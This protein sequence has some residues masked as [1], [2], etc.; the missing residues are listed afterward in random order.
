MYKATKFCILGFFKPGVKLGF[1]FI[2]ILPNK[3]SRTSYINLYFDEESNPIVGSLKNSSSVKIPNFL[4][5]K[6]KMPEI[7]FCFDRKM[8]LSMES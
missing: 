6:M 3:K 2:G 4:H 8:R 1:E 7:K 5:Q